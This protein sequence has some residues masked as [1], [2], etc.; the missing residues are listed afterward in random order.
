MSAP[1]EPTGHKGTSTEDVTH[2]MPMSKPVTACPPHD[3]GPLCSTT[4]TT[5]FGPHTK[6]CVQKT[7]SGR[8]HIATRSQGSSRASE[9]KGTQMKII[10]CVWIYLYSSYRS[11]CLCSLSHSDCPPVPSIGL[12]PHWTQISSAASVHFRFVWP[13]FCRVLPF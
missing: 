13:G 9:A 4:Q 5:K 7:E 8:T 1:T 10:E 11:V 12:L 2:L 6:M 3:T